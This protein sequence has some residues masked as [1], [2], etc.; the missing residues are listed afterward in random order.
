VGARQMKRRALHWQQQQQQQQ[1]QQHVARNQDETASSPAGNL[2]EHVM[3]VQPMWVSGVGAG[4]GVF[5]GVGW[6]FMRV[7][8]AGCGAA[9]PLNSPP[10]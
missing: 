7:L 9:G 10:A 8:P 2:P 6:R 5:S 1:Q 4:V 3:L